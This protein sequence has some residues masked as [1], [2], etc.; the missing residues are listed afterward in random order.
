MDM[1][2]P[3]M[4]FCDFSLLRKKQHRWAGRIRKEVYNGV[5]QNTI[6]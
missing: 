3:S 4:L 1:V 6:S 2:L 5:R